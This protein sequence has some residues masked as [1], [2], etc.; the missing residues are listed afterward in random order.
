MAR[1]LATARTRSKRLQRPQQLALQLRGW[2]GQREGAGRPRV[3]GSIS[4]AARPKL[5]CRFPVHVTLKL[6]ESLPN[7]RTARLIRVVEQCLRE[8]KQ[9]AGFRLVHY[10]VQAHHLHLIVEAQSAQTLSAGVKG[11]SVRVAKRL[12][13]TLGR[14]GRVFVERYFS[15]ILKTPRQTRAAIAYVLLNCRRHDAQ[16]GRSR[17]PG[18]IDPCSSGRFFDGGT[19]WS[20]SRKSQ[21]TVEG[22]V[23]SSTRSCRC[24]FP[25]SS[26]GRE[27]STRGP[28]PCGFVE[29][30]HDHLAGN[31]D[32]AGAAS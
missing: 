5:A 13:A 2:G 30:P 10:G 31:S 3:P 27:G 14:S 18:W 32:G 29:N 23:A 17:D 25:T 21:A 24:G 15:R 16:R 9:R 28:G 11:L 26:T 20:A 6:G 22:R 1:R 19:G 12:N 8:G 4:H 7:L